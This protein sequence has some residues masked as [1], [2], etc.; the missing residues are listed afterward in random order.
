MASR[1]DRIIIV[2]DM[3]LADIDEAL[4]EALERLDSANSRVAEVLQSVELTKT[5]RPES[6]ASTNQGHEPVQE[7]DVL[8]EG[9]EGGEGTAN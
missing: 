9:P 7:S 4:D 2:R 8:S 1:K 5:V 3:D 6:A